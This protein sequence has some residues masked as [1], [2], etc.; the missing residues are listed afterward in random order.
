MLEHYRH[1]HILQKAPEGPIPAIELYCPNRRI[2]CCSS[3]H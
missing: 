3:G 1:G 2:L